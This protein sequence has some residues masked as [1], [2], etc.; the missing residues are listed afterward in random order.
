MDNGIRRETSS[1]YNPASNGMAENGVQ[2]VKK[3]IIRTK[4]ARESVDVAVA[5]FR[6][7]RMQGQPAPNDLFFKR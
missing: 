3:V 6:N 7:S 1:F 4:L 5:E 2:R